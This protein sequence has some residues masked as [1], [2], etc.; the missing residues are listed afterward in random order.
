MPKVETPSRRSDAARLALAVALLAATAPAAP[1][2][3]AR[4]TIALPPPYA[5][6]I[7][8]A[9]LLAAEGG[10][11]ATEIAV[12]A[13]LE[14]LVRHQSPDGRW[15][16]DRFFASCGDPPCSGPTTAPTEGGLDGRGPGAGYRPFDVGVT[17]LA[18]LA[19]LG[20]GETD[21]RLRLEPALRGGRAARPGMAVQAVR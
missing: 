6:R 5:H 13:A 1:A 4:L 20:H 19:F 10:S 16:C 12:V 9:G 3:E 2:Q 15:D 11:E 7:D 21:A 14:W 17:A 18:L 8:R